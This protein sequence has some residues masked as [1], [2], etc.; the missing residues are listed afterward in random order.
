MRRFQITVNGTAY[1]V[2]VEELDEGMTMPAAP[3][4]APAKPQ[5]VSKVAAPA[6]KAEA[7]TVK[8]GTPVPSPMPG[9]ILKTP[10]KEGE[11]V[12]A[13]DVICVL[14]AM[15]MENEIPAPKDGTVA[16]VRVHVGDT[17]SAGDA[18]VILR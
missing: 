13:G 6:P 12:K 10:V 16:S 14:E 1:D 4:K 15:K 8:D 18:L 9:T 3:E 5:T 2:T 7:G 11:C 17:V